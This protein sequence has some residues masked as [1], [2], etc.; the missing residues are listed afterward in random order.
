MVKMNLSALLFPTEAG[1]EELSGRWQPLLGK[2]TSGAVSGVRMRPLVPSTLPRT[3]L[4]AVCSFLCKR[5]RASLLRASRI[6]SPASDRKRH[7][8]FIHANPK[9]VYPAARGRSS[10]EVGYISGCCSPGYGGGE[11]PGA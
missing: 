2:L 10:F 8:G 9:V 4:A 5:R 6:R 11:H 7:N 1:N 3:K